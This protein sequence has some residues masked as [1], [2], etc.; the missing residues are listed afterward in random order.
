[1]TWLRVGSKDWH[2]YCSSLDETT[3]DVPGSCSP[4]LYP[5]VLTPEGL[6]DSSSEP[7]LVIVTESNE[8]PEETQDEFPEAVESPVSQTASPEPPLSEYSPQLPTNVL[9]DTVDV[10]RANSPEKL[11]VVDVRAKKLVDDRERVTKKCEEKREVRVHDRKK[12]EETSVKKEAKL[13]EKERK[14][15]K[16]EP[17]KVKD[18]SS[19][20]GKSDMHPKSSSLKKSSLDTSRSSKTHRTKNE[21]DLQKDSRDSSRDRGEILKDKHNQQRDRGDFS[22][23]ETSRDRVDLSRAEKIKSSSSSRASKTKESDSRSD[24]KRSEEKH[25]HHSNTQRHNDK[26][27]HDGKNSR[28]DDRSKERSDSRRS[29]GESHRDKERSSGKESSRTNKSGRSRERDTSRDS[30]KEKGQEKERKQ[31]DSKHETSECKANTANLRKS[32]NDGTYGTPTGLETVDQIVPQVAFEEASQ[33]TSRDVSHDT[34]RGASQEAS[35]EAFR[36]AFREPSREP[37]QESSQGPSQ[38]S[39]QVPFHKEPQGASPEAILED[40]QGSVE[41][42][43]AREAEILRFSYV[44]DKTSGNC[45]IDLQLVSATSANQPEFAKSIGTCLEHGTR[46][47]S[48]ELPIIDTEAVALPCIGVL[49]QPPRATPERAKRKTRHEKR[50][51]DKKRHRRVGPDGHESDGAWSDVTV[52]S[53]HTSDLSSFDDRISVSSAEEEEDNRQ[54][55]KVPLREI[56]KIASSSN[57][58]EDRMSKCE[59]DLITPEHIT[60]TTTREIVKVMHNNLD[61]EDT[62]V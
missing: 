29:H 30:R 55:K 60:S 7:Q 12:D 5:T 41:L 3:Q 37:S 13:A 36:D 1:M 22:K 57:E 6:T 39:S 52:S 58:D 8:R 10:N 2:P 33:E 16:S 59:S 17:S 54:K 53:V 48:S 24:R 61:M 44:T 56:K 38:E 15:K 26:R 43:E 11:K 19:H 50:S 32:S 14:D 9:P 46:I 45:E 28:A 31:S 34:S 25:R 62:G 20:L 49:E 42:V 35:Q 21:G 18:V 27:R 51:P 47:E 4:K 40:T 23:D